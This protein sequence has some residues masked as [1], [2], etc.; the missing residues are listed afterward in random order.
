MV[1]TTLAAAGTVPISEA[2][3]NG[4]ARRRIALLPLT[5]RVE[6][7]PIYVRPPK[8]LRG[9]RNRCFYYIGTCGASRTCRRVIAP[10]GKRRRTDMLVMRPLARAMTIDRRELITPPGRAS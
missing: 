9:D 3:T 1:T 4:T 2:R 10:D 8:W 5:L 6:L 7:P